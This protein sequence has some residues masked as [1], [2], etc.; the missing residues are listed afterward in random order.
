MKILSREQVVEITGLSSA[1][2]WREERAGRFPSRRQ[3]TANRVG[4][5]EVEVEEW[6]ANRPAVVKEG[7]RQPE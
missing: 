4:W 5:L 3:L 7:P 6:M 2:L 1:T